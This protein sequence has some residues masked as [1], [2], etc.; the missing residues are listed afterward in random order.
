M[1]KRSISGVNSNISSTIK[2]NRQTIKDKNPLRTSLTPTRNTVKS[3]NVPQSS[4]N[5]FTSSRVELKSEII[6]DKP[7]KFPLTVSGINKNSLL[8]SIINM[9]ISSIKNISDSMT[10]KTVTARPVTSGTSNLLKSYRD[11][12][13]KPKTLEKENSFDSHNEIIKVRRSSKSP[14]ISTI[15]RPNFSK[16]P[17]KEHNFKNESLLKRYEEL[18]NRSVSPLTVG[19]IGQNIRGGVVKLGESKIS[20]ITKQSDRENKFANN[21]D[22]RELNTSPLMIRVY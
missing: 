16:S 20:S 9:P 3:S 15:E 19:S 21:P 14:K 17:L 18:K 5:R 1:H 22:F 4:T 7:N 8:K 6:Y 10:K 13:I 12:K 11:E 2:V